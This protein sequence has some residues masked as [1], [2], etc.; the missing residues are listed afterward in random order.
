MSPETF[1]YDSNRVWFNIT[2]LTPYN[3]KEAAV[4]Y[5]VGRIKAQY[6]NQKFKS[7]FYYYTS[8]AD[9]AE[10]NVLST[11][12]E[13]DN[14]TGLMIEGTDW[15]SF[16]IS[17]IVRKWVEDPRTNYGIMIK[18]IVE[19]DRGNEEYGEMVVTSK[20]SAYMEISATHF[21]VAERPKTN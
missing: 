21:R 11:G 10:Y 6:P 15:E 14:M 4:L 17:A 1:S 9:V 2:T 7:K 8:P 5:Y 3:F 20:P 19:D 16:D 18:L 13:H 12:R